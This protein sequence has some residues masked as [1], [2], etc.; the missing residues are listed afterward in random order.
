[1]AEYRNCL[2]PGKSVGIQEEIERSA[3]EDVP[4]ASE[5]KE[6]GREELQQ[7]NG[8]D[9]PTVYVGYDG[10]VYDVSGSRLWKTGSHMKR[11][12]SGTDLSDQLSGAPHGPEV[13]ERVPQVGTLKPE[14]DPM[15]EALPDFLLRLFKKIPMLRRHPHPMTV[16]FPL[17]FNLTFPFFNILYVLTGNGP[18]EKTAFHM[19]VL[20]VPS[21]VVAMMTGPFA[22]W[23]NYG[24]KMSTN[25]KVKL[26]VSCL[27]LILVLIALYWRATNPDVLVNMGPAGWAYLALSSSFAILVGILGWFGAKM[28]FPH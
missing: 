4:M 24:A 7:H 23:V 19:L 1:V 16:H 13:F 5:T 10:K 11:H 6:F 8:K 15:D 17:V 20:C 22:W 21:M 9:Q 28:T 18:F 14:K 25:I 12:T 26:S 27:L 3:R 2:V